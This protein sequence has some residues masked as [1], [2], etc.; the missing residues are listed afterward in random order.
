MDITLMR[1]GKPEIAARRGVRWLKARE[2]HAWIADYN[3]ATV[4]EMPCPRTKS[5]CEAADYI[6]SSPLPRALTSLSTLGANPNAILHELSE[7]PLPV[8]QV[9]LIKFPSGIWLILFR[10]LWLA[11]LARGSEAKAEVRMRAAR[12][13]RKLID[14]AERYGHVVSMG[15][16]ILNKFISLELTRLG[17]I[18]IESTGSGYA[19]YVTWRSPNGTL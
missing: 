15:H 19:S 14:A 5:A 1:H 16:G 11:D 4:A 9:P 10:L 12:V 6:V 2:M 17:W 8:I 18:K 7:A 3:A 13:V